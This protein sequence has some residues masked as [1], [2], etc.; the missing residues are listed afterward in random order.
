M[1]VILDVNSGAYVTSN[2]RYLICSRHLLRTRVVQNN[3]QF[4]SW[5][6]NMTEF[7]S[8]ID[9]IRYTTT[10]KF[11]ILLLT[12]K[13]IWSCL[14]KKCVILYIIL[15][16]SFFTSKIHLIIPQ[17]FLVLVK[18]R[19]GTENWT[20]QIEGGLSRKVPNQN[21]RILQWIFSRQ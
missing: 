19:P 1:V 10:V 21:I 11:D 15:Y 16:C 5:L 3:L 7:L 9:T 14:N 4:P 2:R 6:R 13:C 12:K 20:K 18:H 8:N 17:N